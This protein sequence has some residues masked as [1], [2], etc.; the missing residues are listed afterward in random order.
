MK[1]LKALLRQH[2]A[3]GGEGMGMKEKADAAT[4]EAHIIFEEFSQAMQ[5][6]LG[7]RRVW[8]NALV[9]KIQQHRDFTKAFRDMYRSAMT[10]QQGTRDG[11]T[12]SRHLWFQCAEDLKRAEAMFKQAKFA[13]QAESL[14]EPTLLSTWSSWRP[15]ANGTRTLASFLPCRR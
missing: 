6:Y 8:D 14:P 2:E 11:F 13:A 3:K 15:G 12:S 4:A 9:K 10:S 1:E 7:S 5:E